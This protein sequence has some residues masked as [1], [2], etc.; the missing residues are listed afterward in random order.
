MPYEFGKRQTQRPD[1]LY[2]S[3]DPPLEYIYPLPTT[4]AF[5]TVNAAVFYTLAR[6]DPTQTVDRDEVDGGVVYHIE[7][8]SATIQLFVLH[9]TDHI[10]CIR[11]HHLAPIAEVGRDYMWRPRGDRAE[12]KLGMDA[13]MAAFNEAI[14]DLLRYSAKLEPGVPPPPPA[15]DLEVAFTWQELYYPDMTDKELAERIGV[16]HQTIRNARSR[17]RHTKRAGRAEHKRK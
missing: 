7:F 17:T 14:V 11:L 4:N 6:C 10:A 15:T 1:P 2:A 5:K 8:R 3:V 12:A 13:L 9:I 16:S